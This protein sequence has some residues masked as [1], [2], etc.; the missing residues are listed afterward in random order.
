MTVW[1]SKNASFPAPSFGCGNLG[2]NQPVDVYCPRCFSDNCLL[3]VLQSADCY[4]CSGSASNLWPRYGTIFASPWILGSPKLNLTCDQHEIYPLGLTDPN[5]IPTVDKVD[6]HPLPPIAS[7]SRI[8]QEAI[9]QL[10]S[11]AVSPFFQNAS[12]ASCQAALSVGKIV[13]LAS[14]S[15]GPQFLT[16]F[17]NTLK[18]SISCNETYG[19]SGLGSILTQVIANADVSGYDGQVTVFQTP[20]FVTY[21]QPEL[22]LYVKTSLACVLPLQPYPWTSLIGLRSPSHHRYLLSSNAVASVLACYTFPMCTL[23]LV[24]T[25]SV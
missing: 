2:F 22:R 10:H 9:Q 23:T 4:F 24:R 14:P 18:P 6:P 3:K 1:L 13:A 25:I 15:N 7:P 11:I 8:L 16:E 5:N 20:Y 17:C 12:C 19:V 21:S